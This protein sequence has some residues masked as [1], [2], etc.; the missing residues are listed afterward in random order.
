MTHPCNQNKECS[1][2]PQFPSCSFVILPPLLF[3]NT[4]LFP[5]NHWSDFYPQRLISI[6]QSLFISGIV[7]C[8]IC[9]D[10]TFSTLHHNFKVH[11]CFSLYGYHVTLLLTSIKLHKYIKVISFIHLLLDTWFIPMLAGNNF[12]NGNKTSKNMKTH[13]C[14]CIYSHFSYQT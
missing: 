12:K 6:F 3:T 2:F 10:L 8:P 5:D 13:L 11:L 1:L 7:Q 9:L 14:L 4:F